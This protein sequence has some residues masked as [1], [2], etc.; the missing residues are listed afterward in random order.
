MNWKEGENFTY[1]DFWR[2]GIHKIASE[3]PDDKQK[4]YLSSEKLAIIGKNLFQSPPPENAR[5]P[6]ITSD[7]KEKSYKDV[8]V[9]FNLFCILL[10]EVLLL[11]QVCII[12]IT[13]W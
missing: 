12:I 13:F 9:L 5:F 7:A 6:Y 10:N 11:F 2:H 4:I 1:F 8:C 3:N